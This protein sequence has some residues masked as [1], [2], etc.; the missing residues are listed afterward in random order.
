VE[1]GVAALEEVVDG[2][3]GEQDEG[4]DQRGGHW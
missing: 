4:D 1:D 2:D 3:G